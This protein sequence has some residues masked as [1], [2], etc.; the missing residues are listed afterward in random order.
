MRYGSRGREGP[1]R[2]KGDPGLTYLPTVG[3][4]IHRQ[5]RVQTQG[6]PKVTQAAGQ[7]IL[8][9]DVGA[10][11]VPVHNGHLGPPA[12]GVVTV[13]VSNAPG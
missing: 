7:V 10:L 11:E 13:Q 3:Q 9:E 1:G 8:H 12:Q 4:V 6:K 2:G 5:G